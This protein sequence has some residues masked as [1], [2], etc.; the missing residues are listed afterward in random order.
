MR[1]LPWLV[2]AACLAYGGC[3]FQ[4]LSPTRQLTDQ[5][6]AFNDETRWARIDLAADRV[7]PAYRATFAVSH[8]G[9][10][11]D[12][13]I[14]DADLTHVQLADDEQ[15]ATSLVSIAWYDQATMIVRGSTL[16]QHWVKTDAG[17][18]LDGETI[19]DGDEGLLRLPEEEAAEDAAEDADAEPLARAD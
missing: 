6:Y 10:G 4:N 8:A 14:A 2:A 9:W 13:Q 19:V 1:R 11:R 16:R 5:V 7:A 18:L 3:M 15:T 17:Y 12:I